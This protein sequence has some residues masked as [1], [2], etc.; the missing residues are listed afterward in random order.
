MVGYVCQQILLEINYPSESACIVSSHH[1]NLELHA[2]RMVFTMHINFEVNSKN[3]AEAKDN[4]FTVD[5]I[6]YVLNCPLIISFGCVNV[7]AQ[8]KVQNI[9]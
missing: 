4:S 8:L 9:M 6:F 7:W 3:D 1:K 5:V 2:S